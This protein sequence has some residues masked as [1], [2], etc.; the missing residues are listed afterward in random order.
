MERK[1]RADVLWHGDSAT[2]KI[3]GV[4]Q[5]VRRLPRFSSTASTT[6]DTTI[7]AP[8][9]GRILR[10]EIEEGQHV[11]KGQTLLVLE[12]MKMEQNLVSPR[13]GVVSALTCA[14]NDQVKAD[15]LLISFETPNNETT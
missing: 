9:P 6:T 5:I 15:Q 12:A 1:L 13:D 10:V 2:V 14:A 7:C 11:T 8:M 3:A 4:T